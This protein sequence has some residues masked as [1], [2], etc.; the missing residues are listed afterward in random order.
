MFN[1]FTKAD[2][3]RKLPI[4]KKGGNLPC[5]KCGGS[6][7]LY[8]MCNGGM[9][10]SFDVIDEQDVLAENDSRRFATKENSKP[11]GFKYSMMK[12]NRI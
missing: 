10:Q 1:T 12:I 5:H 7:G 2:D 11:V 9:V 4:G 6:H 3:K 8:K